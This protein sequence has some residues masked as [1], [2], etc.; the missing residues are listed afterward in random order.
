MDTYLQFSDINSTMKKKYK[1]SKPY[2]N[3]QLTLAWKSM[4]QCEK[5]FRNFKGHRNIKNKL[6]N[7]FHNARNSFDKLLRK[8]ERNYNNNVIINIEHLGKNN[9]KQFWNTI[10][11]LGP[12]KR[13]IPLKVEKEGNLVSNVENVLN[14]WKND[15]E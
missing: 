3:E 6:H 13:D 15:F 8:C 1:H 7:L 12:K 2:W 10:K 14:V 11:Q 9:H 5:D 4:T